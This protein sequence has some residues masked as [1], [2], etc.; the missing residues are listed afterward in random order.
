MKNTGLRSGNYINHNNIIHKIEFF[1]TVAKSHAYRPETIDKWFY[2][3]YAKPIVL[4]E[5]WFIKFG[6]TKVGEYFII[7]RLDIDYCFNWRDFKSDYSLSIEYTDSPLPQDQGV[8]YPVTL[9][10]KYVHQL[11]NLFY[12]VSGG[13][14]LIIRN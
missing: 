5:E 6:F 13:E 14:E 8:K 1:E 7:S 2:I 10:T 4:T 9:G 12:W 11:Q 3:N